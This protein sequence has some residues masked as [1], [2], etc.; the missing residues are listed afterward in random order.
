M[1]VDQHDSPTPSVWLTHL[2]VIGLAER[3]HDVMRL[4]GAVDGLK[5]DTTSPVFS[6]FQR[7]RLMKST[8]YAS[9]L[10]K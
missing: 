8:T 5:F 6:D 7:L 10:V 1:Q 2:P 3:A 4:F 9:S